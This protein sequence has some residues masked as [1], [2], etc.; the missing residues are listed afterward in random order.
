MNCLKCK[1]YLDDYIRGFLTAEDSNQVKSHLELCAACNEEHESLRTLLGVFENE[2][3]LE[4]ATGELVNFMP[5]IWG[6]IEAAKKPNFAWAGRLIP[7]VSTVAIL[8]MLVFRPG[9]QSLQLAE[10]K[11]GFEQAAVAYDSTQ[12]N[13]TT[14]QGL[15]QSLFA[16]D[17]VQT[18]EMAESELD[19]SAGVLFS[20]SFENELEYLSDEGLE[21]INRKLSEIRGTEG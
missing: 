19:A 3:P 21:V 2:P 8:A 17:N 15:L 18:L 6:K 9:L 20:G 11:N 12:Y 5:E 16:E 13:Q 1:E 4:I 7:I 10:Q 14:Y